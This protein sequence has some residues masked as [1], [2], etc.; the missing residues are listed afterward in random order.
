[1]DEG[2]MSR[3]MPGKCIERPV[4]L[5]APSLDVRPGGRRFLEVEL[6]SEH[7]PFR[8]GQTFIEA[9]PHVFYALEGIQFG[10]AFGQ[11]VAI[12]PGKRKAETVFKRKFIERETLPEST[13]RNAFK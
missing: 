13:K 7:A 9:R 3:V 12:E 1:M 8:P 11:G 6:E 5:P 4:L 10:K 2:V